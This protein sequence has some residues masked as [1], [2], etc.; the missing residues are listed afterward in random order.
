MY[1]RLGSEVTVLE[2]LDR[3]V[4]GCD[5]EIAKSF[6]VPYRSSSNYMCCLSQRTLEKQNM[7]FRLSTKVTS[8]VSMPTGVR[9]TVS[10]SKGEGSETIDV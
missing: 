6:Q 3:I 4:P 7:K 1:S 5:G 8:A 9:L 2:F 10:P